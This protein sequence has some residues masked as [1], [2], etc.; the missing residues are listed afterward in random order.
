MSLPRHLA[1]LATTV[2]L[3]SCGLGGGDENYDTNANYDT[4]NPYGVPS[5]SYDSPSQNVNP[6]ADNPTYSPAAYEETTT[7]APPS[8]AAPPVT[9]THIVV[10]G[11]TLWGLSQK[12]GVGVADIR[13]ANGMAAND[14]NIRLG[15]TLRIPAR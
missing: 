11:D 4:A 5:S 3:A 7:V 6:P 12:Y 2:A 10:K 14:N 15:S 1:L 8:H 13:A 9:T